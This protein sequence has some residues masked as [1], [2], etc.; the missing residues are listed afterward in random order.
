MLGV[1]SGLGNVSYGSGCGDRL[2]LCDPAR[3]AAGSSA[4]PLRYVPGTNEECVGMDEN[5]NTVVVGIFDDRYQAE[6]AVDELEQS[7]Y[8]H[9]DV[10]FA[11]R[12]NDAVEGGMITDAMGTKDS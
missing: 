9:S 8:S 11:I 4:P 2:T 12:G 10:G 6:Q 3:R 5:P 1:G 7:G